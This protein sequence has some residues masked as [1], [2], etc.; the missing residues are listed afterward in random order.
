MHDDPIP[1]ASTQLT[2]SASQRGLF[3]QN[4]MKTLEP[5]Q[6]HDLLGQTE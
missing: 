6:S 5:K 2:Q 3:P 1:R 4:S